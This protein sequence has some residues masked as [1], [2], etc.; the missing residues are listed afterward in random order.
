MKGRK[1]L[2]AILFGVGCAAT[3]I[4]FLA[5][6]LPGVQNAQLQ[7]VLDSFAN[8]TS[9][10]AARW[11]SELA[12]YALQNTWY[13]LLFGMLCMLIGG[14]L[15]GHFDAPAEPKRSAKRKASERGKAVA[16]SNPF[17]VPSQYEPPIPPPEAA[18]SFQPHFTPLLEEN[19][20]E[21]PL[22]EAPVPEL[23]PIPERFS[24]ETKA[25]ESDTAEP[26]PSGSRMIVRKPLEE[27]EKPAPAPVREAPSAP[28]S[29]SPRI[30][31]TM[32][33]HQLH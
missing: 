10:G 20:I 3:F 28:S 4:G 21:E 32:G 13:V 18:P 33:Q 6:I 1:A 2:S 22:Q 16:A 9:Q 25:I 23:P 24:L 26:S 7:L 5:M 14:I 29:P 27:P 30:R 19:R 15:F 8:P 12:A 17:A 31:S 11:V